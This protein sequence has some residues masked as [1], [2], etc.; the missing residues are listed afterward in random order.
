ME[1]LSF[2]TEKLLSLMQRAAPGLCASSDDTG[3]GFY[4][5]IL[6]PADKV[7]LYH[8]GSG[9]GDSKRQFAQN[10]RTFCKQL[11]APAIG[12]LNEIW[13][14]KE[15]GLDAVLLQVETRSEGTTL[16][17]APIEHGPPRKMGK[18]QWLC[19]E[20]ATIGDG[21]WAGKMTHLLGEPL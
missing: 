1:G 17:F 14:D 11:Q 19:R 18:I 21:V 5:I 12:F 3:F 7:L 10:C 9:E 15:G 2:H 4:A 16:G 13:L 20:D 8:D 6:T